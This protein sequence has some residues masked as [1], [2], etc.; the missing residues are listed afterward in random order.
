MGKK[1]ARY[2]IPPNYGI[3]RTGH[4]LVIQEDETEYAKGNRNMGFLLLIIIIACF[5]LLV[6]NGMSTKDFTPIIGLLAFGI[7]FESY[8]YFRYQHYNRVVQWY[9]DKSL[10]TATYQ[11]ISPTFKELKQIRLS[12]I[13]SLK[14]SFDYY[15]F[16]HRI[17]F[18]LTDNRRILIIAGVRKEDY[19]SFKTNLTDFLNVPITHHK[20]FGSLAFYGLCILFIVGISIAAQGALF[21]G[22]LMVF[23]A[24]IG[25]YLVF[26][27][28]L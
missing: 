25:G 20:S 16:K 28:D 7:G 10:G 12:N 27:K 23:F 21:Q 19:E 9:L 17:S 22:I 18:I 14:S 1:T 2:Y 15:F 26:K 3:E 4:K 8:F 5:P 11:K 13:K 6:L 24:L